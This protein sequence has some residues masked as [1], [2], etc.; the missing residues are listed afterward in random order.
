MAFEE[1][2]WTIEGK[3][4]D[5]GRALRFNLEELRRGGRGG[6]N[7]GLHQRAVAN[8]FIGEI[9]MTV[10]IGAT[11]RRGLGRFQLKGNGEH[12][13]TGK[14]VDYLRHK[15]ETRVIVGV[16]RKADGEMD[17]RKKRWG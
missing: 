5:F 6:L 17:G 12:M 2:L 13:L 1:V 15:S 10:A 3:R 8:L 7:N 16:C 14:E 4:E 9:R 11:K